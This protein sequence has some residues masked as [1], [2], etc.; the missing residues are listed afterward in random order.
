MHPCPLERA[1]STRG[2]RGFAQTQRRAEPGHDVLGLGQPSMTR[3]SVPHIPRGL[4]ELFHVSG[5]VLSRDALERTTHLCRA[6]SHTALLARQVHTRRLQFLCEDVFV[7]DRRGHDSRGDVF[8]DLDQVHAS[9]RFGNSLARSVLSEL[10]SGRRAK[11]LF[12]QQRLRGRRRRRRLCVGV[13]SAETNFVLSVVF[14]FHGG[15]IARRRVLDHVPAARART[16]AFDLDEPRRRR[17]ALGAV[18][19]GVDGK[20]TDGMDGGAFLEKNNKIIK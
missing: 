19:H 10:V 3:Q 18:L 11:G 2:L 5:Q 13:G 7:G 14:M 8:G 15:P 20:V 17:R 16:E 6:A 9:A 12:V 1:L 4:E